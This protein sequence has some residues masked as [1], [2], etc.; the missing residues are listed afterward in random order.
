[1]ARLSKTEIRFMNMSQ[2]EDRIEGMNPSEIDDFLSPEPKSVHQMSFGF[3]ELVLVVG[4]SL[5][6]WVGFSPSFSS[7]SWS[8]SNPGSVTTLK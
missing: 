7:F 2:I 1:M 4:V 8:N 3:S 6:L 5:I